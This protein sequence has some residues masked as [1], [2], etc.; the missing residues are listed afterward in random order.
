[1][2]QEVRWLL[3]MIAMMWLAGCGGGDGAAAVAPP[4]VPEPPAT[5]QIRHVPGVFAASTGFANQCAAP[6]SGIDPA[7]GVAYEDTQGSALAE[8]HFL[9]SWTNELYLWYD[10]VPDIDPAAIM[11][12]LAY[13]DSQKTPVV[14]P[15]GRDK[16][17]YHFTYD[18]AD[19]YALSEAGVS[20]GYGI[21]WAIPGATPPALEV[22][23]QRVEPGS[24]ADLAGV[25]RGDRLV[26]ADGVDLGFISTEADFVTV[27]RAVLPDF[28]SLHELVLGDRSAGTERTVVLTAQAITINPVP[29]VRTQPT[30]TGNVGYLLFTD[31]IATSEAALVDAINQLDAAGVDELV[32]DLRYNGGGYLLIASELAYMI[33]GPG[34]TSGKVFERLTFNGKSTSNAATSIPFIDATLDYSLPP[35]QP[36][37]TLGLARVYV[38]TTGQT[39]S[40]S[41]SVINSLR[42]VGV[43]VIQVGGDTCGKPYGFFPQDNCGTTYFSIQ[44]QSVNEAGFG[45]YAAGFSPVLRPG[46]PA[47]ARLDGCEG[48]DDY[49]HELGDPQ[50]R[51]FR[52]A[53]RHR[54]DGF[55]EPPSGLDGDRA[56]RARAAATSSGAGLRLVLPA[57]PWRH[58][59]IY[60]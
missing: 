43:E 55:C 46:Q 38:L 57:E 21:Y 12:V 31:H 40:A 4:V 20:G 54:V 16:D 6:R 50:E 22:V 27:Q 53:L 42:G 17:E 36:L 30:S 59:R 29:V 41:E 44:M 18:T 32:L 28:G 5:P 60:R 56:G 34:Q 15:N 26:R 14:L 33:A 47:G 3:P 19:Y 10:E 58:N 37:P 11:D 51:L 39:C 23:V 8:K 52:M 35:G 45:D 2:K 25:R 1:M 48:H 24:P 7:T 13:F 9:R 49:A